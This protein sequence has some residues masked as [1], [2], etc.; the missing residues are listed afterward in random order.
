MILTDRRT[1]NTCA[2]R[3]EA[4]RL[5]RLQKEKSAASEAPT[6][7]DAGG[8][9]NK[10]EINEATASSTDVAPVLSSEPITNI[11]AVPGVDVTADKTDSQAEIAVGN[12]KSTQVAPPDLPDTSKKQSS[13]PAAASSKGRLSPREPM[14]G[15]WYHNSLLVG[16]GAGFA[17]VA[18]YSLLSAH[19]R[20][21][22]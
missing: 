8:D 19:F 4:R 6:E 3:K 18:L 13:I 15:G 11:V 2:R 21:P 7:S 22:R 5:K 1:S 10:S 20:R 14:D 9:D 12:S 17:I 16:V